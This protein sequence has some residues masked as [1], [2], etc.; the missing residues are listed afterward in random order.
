MTDITFPSPE[1]RPFDFDLKNLLHPAQAF[2]HPDQVLLDR[3]LTLAEKRAILA[4]WVSD[5]CAVEAMPALRQAPGG[6]Q[7][8]SV[9]DILTALRSLDREEPPETS[10][11]RRTIRR[12]RLDRLRDARARCFSVVS[13]RPSQEPPPKAA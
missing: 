6:K 3:D 10:H 11:W 7:P 8:V 1:R 12:L 4:S 13:A 5:A 9:D 2:E